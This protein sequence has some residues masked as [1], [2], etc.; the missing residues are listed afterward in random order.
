MDVEGFNHP[1][2]VFFLPE[3]VLTMCAFHAI[4]SP[5]LRKVENGLGN[6]SK[7]LLEWKE[8]IVQWENE[9]WGR[10]GDKYQKVDKETLEPQR[11]KNEME[12]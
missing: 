9:E 11:E 6:L 12:S 4:F 7:G 3:A 8:E 5:Y 10:I 2:M 1:I